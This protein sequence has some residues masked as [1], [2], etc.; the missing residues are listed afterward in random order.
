MG[1]SAFSIQCSERDHGP[2][3]PIHKSR[4][5][6]FAIQAYRAI[7][8][9]QAGTTHCMISVYLPTTTGVICYVLK[10]PLFSDTQTAKDV[11]RVME[12]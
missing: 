4:A 9:Q 8:I 10:T 7:R 1:F 3:L 12:D 11:I 5:T 2:T 6:F